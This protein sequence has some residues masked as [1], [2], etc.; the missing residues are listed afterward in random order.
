MV[1]LHRGNITKIIKVVK[2]VG[3]WSWAMGVRRGMINLDTGNVL[4]AA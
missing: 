3:S 2:D 1:R 4:N